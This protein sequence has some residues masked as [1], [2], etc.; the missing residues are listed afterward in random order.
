[1]INLAQNI[2]GA[3]SN[4]STAFGA[5]KLEVTDFNN[6]LWDRIYTVGDEAVGALT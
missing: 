6:R 3:Q 2:T 4:S 5:I 1:M